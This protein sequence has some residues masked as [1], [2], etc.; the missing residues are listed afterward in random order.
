MGVDVAFGA[1]VGVSVGMFVTVGIGV[2]VGEGQV[3]GVG[4]T[5]GVGACSIEKLSVQLWFGVGS[6]PSAF[7]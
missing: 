5:V 3:V 6:S 4:P 1:L 7:G 2:G